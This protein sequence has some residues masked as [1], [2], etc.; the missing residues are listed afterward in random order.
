MCKRVSFPLVSALRSRYTIRT[1]S[2]PSG[3]ITFLFI[4]I[5]GSIDFVGNS[6]KCPEGCEWTPN[7]S[8]KT[9]GMLFT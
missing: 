3:A 4:G 2:L 1:E 6:Q 5:E 7:Y 8:K 9:F